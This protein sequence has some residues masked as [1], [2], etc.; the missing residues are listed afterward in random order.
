MSKNT[1]QRRAAIEHMDDYI[2]NLAERMLAGA[3]TSETD[4]Y[5]LTMSQLIRAAAAAE[6]RR[7]STLIPTE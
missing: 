4:A 7:L 3:D 1:A 6:A 2:E 5:D